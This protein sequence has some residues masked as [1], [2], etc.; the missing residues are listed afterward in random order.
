MM[1]RPHLLGPLIPTAIHE[2]L[3]PNAL[4][5]ELPRLGKSAIE[6]TEHGPVVMPA[7]V[8]MHQLCHEKMVLVHPRP[9][10]LIAALVQP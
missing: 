6:I 3:A 2:R 9:A 10:A 5:R 4:Q 8:G 7:I 1:L